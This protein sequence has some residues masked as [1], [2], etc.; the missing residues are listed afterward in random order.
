MQ[1][2]SSD[3]GSVCSVEKGDRPVRVLHEYCTFLL[4]MTRI[5][6]QYALRDGA[7][8]RKGGE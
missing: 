7:Y 8:E 3:S 1:V 5:T 6:L 4:Y 2:S